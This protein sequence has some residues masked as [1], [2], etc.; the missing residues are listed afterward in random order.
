MR[1]PADAAG[2]HC[3]VDAAGHPAATAER[4]CAPWVG[5][6]RSGCGCPRRRPTSGPG[7]TP[8]GSRWGS[9]TRSTS[10]S[11]PDGLTVEVDGEGAAGVPRDERHLVV[12]AMR[13]AFEVFGDAPPGLHLRC[14]NA[15]PHAR[16]LGSSAA[17]VVAGR[18]RGGGA[19][20]A[21]TPPPSARRCC[22]SRPAWRAT[23]TTRRRAC[24]ADSCRLGQTGIPDRFD[25]VRLDAHP[26]IA[27]VALV[28]ERRVVHGDDARAAARR[29]PARRRGVHRKPH[30]ARRPRL[31]P[32]PRAAAARHRGPAA[33]GVPAPGLPGV[34]RSGRRAA[35]AGRSG[36][37]LRRRTDRPGADHGRRA[38]GRAR[39]ARFHRA[40]AAGRPVRRRGRGR[41]DRASDGVSGWGVVAAADGY[42]YP[43]QRNGD[44]RVSA[45]PLEPGQ[46]RSLPANRPSGPSPEPRRSSSCPFG[47]AADA[48]LNPTVVRHT[49]RTSMKSADP[50][51]SPVGQEGPS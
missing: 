36:R 35:G 25:A 21:A 28:A 14:R 11:L 2:W 38:A 4:G 50:G 13:R 20:R 12:R 19:R 40:A 45:W 43:R 10:P 33:P 16:G 17:A 42:V 32:A 7:S 48:A 1:A 37:D 3:Y 18:G 15:I 34:G 30:R 5:P 31:H 9:T 29:G 51:M 23:P 6:P 41:R 26:G 39:P 47:T 44:P 22:S 8:S 49:V 24:S 46:N 27:P